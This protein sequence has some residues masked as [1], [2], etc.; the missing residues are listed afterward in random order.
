MGA[1]PSGGKWGLTP[2][3][4]RDC[5]DSHVSRCAGRSDPIF[6]VPLCL[7]VSSYG[8]DFEFIHILYDR[9]YSSQGT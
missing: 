6:S 1:A 3:T 8:R 7:C 5:S 2:L 4:K 9:V